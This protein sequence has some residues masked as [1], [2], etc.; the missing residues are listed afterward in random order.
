MK[1][2]FFFGSAMALGA[3]ILASSTAS[4]QEVQL[5]GPLKGA[6][7]VRN[8]RLYREGRFEVAPT[9]SFTL[10]DEYR[11]TMIVG[12][13]LNYNIKDWLGVGVWGGYG[14]VSLN[15]DL[16]D[17][18]DS[19]VDRTDPKNMKFISGNVNPKA[20]AFADSQVAKLT[21]FVAPQVQFVP[22]RGKL[23]LFHKLF[24]DTD[25]FLHGGLA[26]V[27]VQERASCGAPGAKACSESFT[28]ESRVAIAP[29]FGLGFNFYPTNLFSFGVEYR[30]FPFSWNRAGFDQRGGGPNGKFPDGKVDDQDR[31]FKWNQM[32][33]VSLS[34]S[35]PTNPEIKP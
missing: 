20:G 19:R 23:A 24:V 9:I 7:A 15:T 12:A 6:P 29:T 2:Q 32:V 35:F 25:F 16:T 13:R 31:T 27:G 5:T 8:L 4:A 21:W 33:S 3:V 26:M 22:F 18:I 17:Q 30:A 10:L 11:R 1:R 28:L 14:V 34:F